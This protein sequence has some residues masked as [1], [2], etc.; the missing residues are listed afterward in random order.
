MAKYIFKWF[1]FNFN[2]I[3]NITKRRKKKNFVNT[4][5]SNFVYFAIYLKIYLNISMVYFPYGLAACHRS[6]IL[7]I[8]F[9]VKIKRQN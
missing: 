2:F 5:F 7:F 4:Y 1:E 8:I 6:L 3:L 9:L